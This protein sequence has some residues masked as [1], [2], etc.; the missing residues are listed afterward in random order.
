MCAYMHKEFICVPVH[1]KVFANFLFYFFQFSFFRIVLMGN[2]KIG[3]G[4][5]GFRIV[6]PVFKYPGFFYGSPICETRVS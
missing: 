3:L 6:R 1:S 5:F 2:F 4:L